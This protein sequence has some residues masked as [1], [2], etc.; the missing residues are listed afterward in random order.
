MATHFKFCASCMHFVICKYY[1][2][3]SSWQMKMKVL[4]MELPQSE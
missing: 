3:S 2:I 4:Q 1:F